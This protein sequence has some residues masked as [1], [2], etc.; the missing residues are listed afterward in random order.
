MESTAFYV[1]PNMN[2][3]GSA[4]GNLRTNASGANLN[5]EWLTPSMES[6]PEVYL[7]R[8]RMMLEG[9][10]IFLDI[11][12]D[13][14]IPYNFLAGAEGVP[15]FEER[16]L[17]QQDDF[18]SAFLEISP[19]FQIEYGY[20]VDEPGKADMRLATNWIG[21]HFKALSFTLEM[22]FKDHDFLPD[23]ITAWSPE[24]SAKLGQDILFPIAKMLSGL[25]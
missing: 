20:P 15:N 9:G 25:D 17:K 11:H 23:P 19:D 8:Q 6:S 18:K 7:V 3:D 16:I 4:R 1:V 2:P 12:G 14:A 13:E 10:Q 24:R 5:R 21:N 22:P